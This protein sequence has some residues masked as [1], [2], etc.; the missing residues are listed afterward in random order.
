MVP[1]ER[2]FINVLLDMLVL[3]PYINFPDYILVGIS[4]TVFKYYSIF[5]FSLI[6]ILYIYKNKGIPKNVLKF[7]GLVFVIY[8]IPIITTINKE[9]YS[10]IFYGLKILAGMISA[11]LLIDYNFKNRCKEFLKS[12]ITFWGFMVVIN[13]LSFF[14]F[15]PSMDPLQ[16]AFYFLGNDNGSIYETLLFVFASIFY[17]IR[18]NNDKIPFKFWL[19]FLFIFSGYYYVKSGNGMSCIVL[20]GFFLAFRNKKIVLKIM[21][22]QLFAGIYVFLF[23]MIVCLRD[24]SFMKP[25]LEILGKSSTLTG[26]TGIWDR[27]LKYIEINKWFG[28]GYE[29]ALISIYKIGNV[30]AHNIILQ[31]LYN[32]GIMMLLLFGVLNL[33]IIKSINKNEKNKTKKFLMNIS[34]FLFFVISLFDFYIQ[35]YTYI[36]MLCIYYFFIN[37]FEKE[38]LYNGD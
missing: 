36:F 15:Y 23:L 20:I 10:E 9:N 8:S 32:G 11:V 6:I 1:K 29:P 22:P 34:I 5:V 28:N 16:S 30:K 27:C 35:K 3:L 17:Y 4:K 37:D 19:I 24:L 18:F 7:V 13:V 12:F 21:K 25:V 38:K 26:R 31:F 33:K 14:I 2:K